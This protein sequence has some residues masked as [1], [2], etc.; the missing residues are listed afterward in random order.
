[1]SN[2]VKSFGTILKDNRYVKFQ[3]SKYQEIKKEKVTKSLPEQFNPIDK[4]GAFLSPVHNQGKCGACWAVA[5]AK[6]L[7][8]RYSLLSIGAFTDIL[9]PYQMIMCQGTV[10]PNIPL[11]DKSVYQINLDA[12]TSGACN[13]NSLFT[14]MDFLYSI[15]CVS[16]TCVSRGLFKKYNIPDIADIVSSES[17]PMCQTIIGNNY[18][19]CMD[20]SRTPCFYRTIV[21]YQVDSDVE[22]IKQEMYKWGPVVGGFK[23][24]ENFLNK[25]DGKTIYT[26]PEKDEKEVG[27]H[28]V[29]I[30]GWGKE[31]GVDFWWLCNSWGTDW[32]LSGLFKM[33]M[34]IPECELEKNVV[35][36]I[37][38]FPGFN[39]NMISYPVSTSPELVALRA[40]MNINPIYGYKNSAIKEIKAGKIKGDLEP[41][42]TLKIPD[43]YTEWLGE[44]DKNK[45]IPYY[46]VPHFEQRKTK[47]SYDYV[48]LVI[49]FFII[50]YY[51]GKYF[52]QR[53]RF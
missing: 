9:S 21:G 13:G 41:I 24:Y 20:R 36:F 37:P 23:V 15:G 8:D 22:S 50:C 7:T 42:F 26:G 11:D 52:G 34:N 44:L 5:T 45:A 28:S 48:F 18:D 53:F 19:R 1:M 40:W 39:M 27:G 12:H 51:T 3:A 14:A 49:V 25:Y 46:S 38:D 10:F 4:W 30:V 17:V 29:E 16:E 2:I 35:G 6:A 33:K 43:M 47:L 31:N 32:G